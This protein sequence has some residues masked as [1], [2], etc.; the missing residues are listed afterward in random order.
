MLST[1]TRSSRNCSNIES[2]DSPLYRFIFRVFLIL[3][4]RHSRQRVFCVIAGKLCTNANLR[5]TK[6]QNDII[7]IF[8]AVSDLRLQIFTDD[9]R[10]S[11]Q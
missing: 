6:T 10:K 8:V 5:G 7:I 9:A 11:G 4:T 2:F 3:P 1:A